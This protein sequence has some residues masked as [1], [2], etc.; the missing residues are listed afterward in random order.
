MDYVTG[1]SIFATA[2]KL[3]L[4]NE[5]RNSPQLLRLDCTGTMCSLRREPSPRFFKVVR[6]VESTSINDV[7]LT[8]ASYG[9]AMRCEI[10]PFILIKF[11]QELLILEQL[12]EHAQV[13]NELD[14]FY[15]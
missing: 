13:L 10:I 9:Q 7:Q 5:R 14:K 11:K 2:A 4:E 8:L 15:V 3:V 12:I 6:S 1:S